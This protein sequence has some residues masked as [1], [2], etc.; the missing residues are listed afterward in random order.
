MPLKDVLL[1]TVP[2]RREHGMA[3]PSSRFGEEA[4]AG[5]RG[6]QRPQALLGFLWERQGRIR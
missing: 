1:L 4:E 6:K 5:A 3:R 2:E